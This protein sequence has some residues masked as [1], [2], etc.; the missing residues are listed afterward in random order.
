M[1]VRRER[2]SVGLEGVESAL[3]GVRRAAV[4]VLTGQ[5]VLLLLTG[6]VGLLVGLVALDALLR[7]P[8]WI[9]WLHWVGGVVGIV[10][11]LGWYVWPAL[12]FRPSLTDVA[13]RVER[14]KEGE[15]G[16]LASAVEFARA[17]RAGEM[18]GGRT[19]ELAA[20][21]VEAEARG[22]RVE[23]ARGLM[24]LDRLRARG[25]WFVVVVLVSVGAGLLH[26]AGARVGAARALSPWRGVEWP[27]RTEVVDA[28]G[29]SVQARG[30][31]IAL[32][33]VVTRSTRPMGE[34]RVEAEYRVVDEQGR[35][36]ASRRA[37]LTH[38]RRE[39]GVGSARGG[40]FE[41]LVEAEGAWVEYR[42]SALDDV[43][44]WN[45]VRVVE[46]PAVERA[47]VVIE[48]PAYASGSSGG[49]LGALVEADLGS[50]L[51]DRAMGPSALA[52]SLVELR[53][54]LN[55]EVPGPEESTDERAWVERV[56]GADLA[57]AGAQVEVD[58][59]EWAARWRLGKGARVVVRLED[60]WGIE[61]AEEAVYRFEAVQDGPA[62]AI[63][64]EPASDVTVLSTA[65]VE[66]VGEGRDDVGL[67]GVWLERQVMR[68]AGSGEKSVPGGALEAWG[69]VVE[70]G[71]AEVG[72]G[73]TLST[74]RGVLEMWELG[75][76]SGDEVW[77][78]ALASDGYRDETASREATRSGVRRVRVISEEQF[79][80]EVRSELSGIR[81]TAIRIDEAQSELMEAARARGTDR[82]TR[83]GQA[84]V[85]ERLARQA[86]SLER[87]SERVEQNGLR[88]E[89]L[90][91][92]LRDA[93]EGTQR[94]GRS[95][96]A[97]GEGLE[98]AAERA[99]RE[100][101]ERGASGASEVDAAALTGEEGRAVAG[102]QQSV[103]DEL[104]GLIGSLDA[105]E[106]AW[107][108]RR[109]IE[110]LLEAQKE[111]RE[112]LR[113]AANETAGA[114]AGA[115]TES[116][117]EALQKVADA[118]RSMAERAQ[119]LVEEMPSK[120]EQLSQ[121]DP[122]AAAGMQRAAQEARAAGV[123]SAMQRAGEQA[124]QNQTNEAMGSQER[125]ER[126]LEKMLEEME[127]GEKTR[128]EQLRRRL[129]SVMESIEG[130]IGQQEAELQRLSE[131][132]RA[133]ALAGLD[134]GMIG[135]N[136]NTLAVQ[137]EARAAGRELAGV[138]NLLGRASDAQVRAIGGL[139]EASIDAGATR[140]AEE[141][142]LARLRE[143]KGEAE[144][145]DKGEEA[146]EQQEKR[147][148]L[149]T[150]YRELLEREQRIRER[151]GGL[152][153]VEE[154][155]RRDRA[156][157]RALGEEQTA[158]RVEL[159]AVLEQTKDLQEAK[160]F[161]FTHARLDEA[162]GRAAD[163]LRV[164]EARVALPHVDRVVSLL[165][166]LMRAL[167]NDPRNDK[168]EKFSENAGGESGG[169][170]GGGESP[171]IP[172]LAELVLLRE[173][174]AQIAV[175]TRAMDEAREGRDVEPLSA[176]QRELAEIGKALIEKMS[177]GAPGGGGS[178]QGGGGQ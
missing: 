65:R 112:A 175:E 166:G 29:V 77:V 79:V 24:R 73:E 174:Q 22:W 97:A 4:V 124:E 68:R 85:G 72:S 84:Q 155:T 16:R 139:R 92:L 34:T 46:A 7:F 150:A 64:S 140:A 71:R 143:A 15:R 94:A 61:S 40:L 126:A 70:A 67:T 41:R 36:G 163:G 178:G 14:E 123:S 88:D 76:Q 141:E 134:G 145:V 138:V 106:D 118:Q 165:Q 81:R 6:L 157:V 96:R 168:E 130:L 136:R 107:A 146:R 156:S 17:L 105:G 58:G 80:E 148:A 159:A 5:R 89:G 111:A 160:I 162:A 99:K 38:Q 51:D 177:R 55:K 28:T 82:M 52:G 110:R 135:L 100:A 63:V 152:A 142:S 74:A 172:P 117:R 127:R 98:R 103:R 48:P 147:R 69:E 30:S 43:T 60:A 3:R 170:Q 121:Q 87:L 119:K 53:L 167:S 54:T 151:V 128:R 33:G 32:R 132:E 19:E 78:W 23:S 31:S 21:V 75:A 101:A 164:G 109:E 153:S 133:G 125:A 37:V 62:S 131:G 11:A 169:G 90:A 176:A 50:G 12:R 137:D 8:S 57:E 149:R 18:G 26:P 115:L 129:A 13:L 173:M 114:E 108:T 95:S 1:D 49:K 91:R 154:L 20:R 171:L 56:L 93:G 116:Q 158:V 83:S 86:E 59:K 42:L 10:T 27:K 25:L 120:S 104:A 161:V 102:D 39:A 44:A 144:K 47:R 113:A 66:I 35:A 122:S 9:R 45:R 2:G